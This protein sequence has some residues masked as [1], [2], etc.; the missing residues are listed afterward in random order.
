MASKKIAIKKS[1]W[2]LALALLV[3]LPSLARAQVG[4]REARRSGGDL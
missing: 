1:G 3:L 4:N 2:A